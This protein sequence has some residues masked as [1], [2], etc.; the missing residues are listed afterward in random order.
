[1]NLVKENLQQAIPSLVVLLDVKSFPWDKIE[2]LLNKKFAERVAECKGESIIVEACIYDVIVEARKQMPQAIRLLHFISKLFEDLAITLEAT[3]KPLIKRTIQQMLE[4]FDLK[5]LNFV[6]ELAALNALLKSGNYQLVSLEDKMPNG[7]FVD[8]KLK[9]VGQDK[10]LLV[11]VVNIHLDSSKVVDD[12]EAIR[13]RLMHKLSRKIEDK[14]TGL[15]NNVQFHLIPVVWGDWQDIKIY[16]EFFKAHKLE[17][18]EVTEPVAYLNLHDSEGYCE[19]HFGR[20]STL[21]E[22]NSSLAT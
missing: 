7:K 1:M 20:V 19:H 14:R 12:A 4:S 22:R 2:R 10:F 21:F 16:S 5:Y 3:E 18:P 9:Q 8:F 13:K 11:E 15:D 17:L 6:G